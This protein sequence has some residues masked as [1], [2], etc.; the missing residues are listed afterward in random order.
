MFV[1]NL[2]IMIGKFSLIN[3]ELTENH[4]ARCLEL[5]IFIKSLQQSP[6]LNVS[7]IAHD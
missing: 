3:A 4:F 6:G 1:L 2:K 5:I 7:I